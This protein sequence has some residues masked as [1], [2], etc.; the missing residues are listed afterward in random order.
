MNRRYFLRAS[1]AY[2]LFYATSFSFLA[3]CLFPSR[4]G[5]P[6][7]LEMNYL[8]PKEMSYSAYHESQ[9]SWVN[10]KY[11][12]EISGRYKSQGKLQA[13]VDT[14]YNPNLNS[15]KYIYYF[16]D[17][18]SAKLFCEEVVTKCDVD[19]NIRKSLGIQSITYINGRLYTK[20]I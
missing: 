9:T 1:S 10:L 7:K 20:H 8:L 13:S 18:T 11:F 19:P 3:N 5:P 15:I 12:Y 17:E 6:A 4:I 16:S 2:G 14:L